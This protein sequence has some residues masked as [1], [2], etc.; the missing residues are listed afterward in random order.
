VIVLQKSLAIFVGAIQIEGQV[1]DEFF[2]A[3]K[4]TDMKQW[5]RAVKKFYL[6]YDLNIE[7]LLNTIPS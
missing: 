1:G 5:K 3:L 2:L 7:S 6:N 4:K